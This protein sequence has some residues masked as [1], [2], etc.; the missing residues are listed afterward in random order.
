MNFKMIG[1][2]TAKMLLIEALFM[3]PATLISACYGE[4]KSFWGFLLSVGIIAAVCGVLYLLSRGASK[5]FYAKEGFVCVG[6]S[7]IVHPLTEIEF[8]FFSTGK[9]PTIVRSLF[10]FIVPS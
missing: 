8:S 5:S 3:L 2:F 10:L 4:K 1:R 6:I 9:P 7:W